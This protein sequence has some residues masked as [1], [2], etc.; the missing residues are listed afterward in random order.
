MKN[1]LRAG[2]VLL[3]LV[4]MLFVPA[5]AQRPSRAKIPF[6]FTIGKKTLKAGEYV[7]KAA[8]SGSVPELL[9]FQDAHGTPRAVVNGVRV[10]AVENNGKCRLLFT[11]YGN[12]YFLS[13]I[14]LSET[15][16][17]AMVR[18]GPLERELA[19]EAGSKSQ[20]VAVLLAK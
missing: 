16:S 7:I 1:K 14:W 2:L 8:G 11:K 10:E 17:G 3:G 6:D 20:E 15:E 19:K 5:V 4:V 12:Q 18:K 13:Q 9:V